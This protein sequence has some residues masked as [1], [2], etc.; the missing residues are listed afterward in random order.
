MSS[1]PVRTYFRCDRASTSAWNWGVSQGEDA[2]FV[3]G[4]EVDEEHV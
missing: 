3:Y 4:G 1:S 2:A